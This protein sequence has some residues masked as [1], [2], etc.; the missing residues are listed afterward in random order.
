MSDDADVQQL[1]TAVFDTLESV[2]WMKAAAAQGIGLDYDPFNRI[3]VLAGGELQEFV[4]THGGPHRIVAS[5]ADHDVL[6]MSQVDPDRLVYDGFVRRPNM[7]IQTNDSS[8]VAAAHVS[9][10]YSGTGPRNAERE[11][12]GLGI[13][14]DLA[15]EIAT[16]RVSDVRLDQPDQAV[17]RADWPLYPLATQPVSPPG[18]WCQSPTAAR[19]TATVSSNE[20]DETPQRCPV[21]L[22]T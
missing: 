3:P 16:N 6:Y 19:L 11:L 18:S 10:G 12:R 20:P 13:D 7:M 2:T 22:S 21:G 14:E 17:H 8:W 5:F 15:Y 9:V 4:T 1:F